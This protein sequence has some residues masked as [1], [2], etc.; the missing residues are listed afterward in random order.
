MGKYWDVQDYVEKNLI[1]YFWQHV[2]DTTGINGC[3]V[4]VSKAKRNYDTISVYNGYK[5]T[6]LALKLIIGLKHEHDDKYHVV[7]TCGTINC[8]NPFHLKESLKIINKLT[9]STFNSI[10][11]E[12]ILWIL[13]YKA[14]FITVKEL[15]EFYGCTKSAIYRI[16]NRTA[17]KYINIPEKENIPPGIKS[18]LE[19]KNG[20]YIP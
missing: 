20:R 14:D 11:V 17:W 5:V 12:T 8:C 19:P 16:K 18:F 2:D 3:W 13:T 10:D 4:Y 6:D 1:D 9:G 7:N 15:A